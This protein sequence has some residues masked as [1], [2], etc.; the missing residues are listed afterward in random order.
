MGIC[1]MFGML[2]PTQAARLAEAGLDFN[3][4][5]IDTSPEFYGKIITTC[6]LRDPTCTLQD[7]VDMLAH[8]RQSGIK[9][10]CGGIAMGER[11]EDRFGMLVLLANLPSHPESV[12][13]NLRNGVK[14]AP[15]NDVAERTDP[16]ALVRLVATTRIIESVVWSSAG[17]QYMTDAAGAVLLGRRKFNF[18]GDVL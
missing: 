6:T 15:T 13:I 10:G 11:V 2:T 8:V 3:N 1:V 17:Q 4:H 14:G 5:N 16:V 7:R 12:P 18:I 9:F